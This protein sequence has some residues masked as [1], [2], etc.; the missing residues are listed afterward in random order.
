MLFRSKTKNDLARFLRG[1]AGLPKHST[2][3]EEAWSPSKLAA[4]PEL[5]AG[6]AAKHLAEK[7]KPAAMGHAA[8]L[9]F[10]MANHLSLSG[11]FPQGSNAR[12]GL[13][14]T[15]RQEDAK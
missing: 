7:Q 14:R 3:V 1:C 11:S 4:R 2:W 8:R 5:P 15:D 10:E 9:F 6:L 13:S 12:V